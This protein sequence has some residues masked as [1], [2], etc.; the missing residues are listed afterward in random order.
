MKPVLQ[1]YVLGLLALLALWSGT[2]GAFAQTQWTGTWSSAPSIASDDGFDNQTI[3]HI[4]R[5][6]IGGTA[7]RVT[8][9][10]LYGT[11]P[12]TIG[13]VHLARR[14]RGSAT[15]AGTDRLVTFS[16]QPYVTIPAGGSVQSDA[17]AFDVPALADLAVS[18]HVP[19]KTPPNSTGNDLGLQDVYIAP[20]DVSADAAFAGGVA[21]AAGGQSVYFLTGIDVMN[22]AAT[23][24]VVA[25]G[26]SITEGLG[27]TP[28]G[29]RRWPNRLAVRLARAGMTVGVLSE[30]IGGNGFFTDG[31]GQAGLTRFARD[32]LGQA[33]VKWVIVSDEAVNS[34]INDTPPTATQLEDAYRR[35]IGQAHAAQLGVVCSTL[36]P[37]QGIA[38]W[39]PAIEATREQINGF[40]RDRA[41]SGCDA[42]LDQAE[43][44]GDV[45]NQA[46]YAPAFDS[47][48]H[49]H[50]N[51][52]GAQAI[53]DAADL[54][55]FAALPAV[56]APGA[57]GRLAPGEG[58][59]VGG[60]LAACS[61]GVTLTV[62]D[63]GYLVAMQNGVVVWS[64]QNA[65][66]PGAE[67]RME[68][69]GNLVLYDKNGARVWQTRTSGHPGAIALIQKDGHLVIYAANGTA[70]W[71]SAG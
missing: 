40:L 6:S 52:A 17:V 4:V 27:T 2:P 58:F 26:A 35:V 61:G 12:V 5:T 10:N 42:V 51:D 39:T 21:N 45:G 29:N 62:Q 44:T 11:Q 14:A 31:A 68:A 15:V 24:A 64:S 48:D 60:A 32:V 3:R 9:S 25:F 36:T 66:P 59:G 65:G 18:L 41:S 13:D 37:F 23:G 67:V 71:S 19:S 46:A 16:G 54:S 38:E 50:P 34:L 30:A 20:G 57:C 55:W 22:A 69:D 28:N 70:L 49:L 43:A 8:L 47:G 33:N 53:A 56:N 7:A 1:R 63:D